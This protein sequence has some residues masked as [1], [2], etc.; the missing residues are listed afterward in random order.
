MR[1]RFRQLL[2]LILLGLFAATLLG[3]GL[4]SWWVHRPH[5]IY[6]G[7]LVLSALEKPVTV[8]YG[9]HAVPSIQ[10]ETL[11]DMLFA[12]GFVVAAERFWQMD[13]LRR[14]AGGRLAELFGEGALVADRFYRTIGLPLAAQRS[15]DALE[16]RWQR[17]LQA[18]ADGVNAYLS[19]ARAG[20]R[21]PLEYQLLGLQ[22]SPW[23]PQDSLLI[24]GYMAWLNSMNLREELVFLRLAQR[25]GTE[26]ALELFPTDQGQPAPADAHELPDYRSL[27]DI[28]PGSP[29]GAE[30]EMGPRALLVPP[31]SAQ[32]LSNAW[33]VTGSRTHDGAALLA[34]DP[35]LP[36]VMPGTWYELEMQ[37]P[38]Y[39]VAGVAL[40]GVPWILIGHNADLA[41]GITAAAADTQDLFLERVSEDGTRV[42]RPDGSWEPIAVRVERIAVAGQ[43]EPAEADVESGAAVTT[44]AKA[45]TRADARASQA[46]GPSAEPSVEGQ[47]QIE[48]PIRSTRHGV[49]IDELVASAGSNPAGLA[50]VRGSQRSGFR[51]A[52]RLAFDR[53]DRAFVGFYRLNTATTIAEARAAV[54]DLHQVSLSLLFAHRDGEIASQVSG[55]LP[56]RGR[57]SGTF[58]V[59]GWEP[60]YGWIGYRPFAQN[61]GITAPSDE[62]LVSANNAIRS[63]DEDALAISHS[64]LAPFRAQRIEALLDDAQEKLDLDAMQQMQSDRVSLEAAVYLS[65]LRRHLPAI[66]RADPEA[67]A[68][69]EANL[70][71]WSGGFEDESQP[72]AFFVLLRSELYRALYADELGSDLELLMG[73]DTNTYGPLAEAMYSDQSSFWDDIET[74]GAVEGPAAIWASALRATARAMRDVMPGEQ[75]PTLAQL[76]QLTFAH[77]FDGQP[78]LGSLFNLGPIGRG[79]DSGTIDVAIAPPTSPRAIGNVASVR[80]IFAPAVWSQ[81]RGTL[82]L[83]QSGH[84]FSRYRADQLDDW[85]NGRSHAWPWADSEA[86]PSVGTLVLQPGPD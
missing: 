66:R 68:L 36:A 69:A 46:L 64:W 25:L 26:R 77:A 41:W 63:D 21:L 50:A 18:Y 75:E 33:A 59:P 58:P 60:G 65:S 47:R 38:G 62:R 37:A 57:G 43:F 24:G 5:P 30:L 73:L 35:H 84:R 48:L 44:D 54:E 7:T 13:L 2:R 76:R 11:D 39:H 12:Q 72:A 74:P 40:P 61:P 15:F 3:V 14:L 9:P 42:L 79:G 29:S 31:A 10:A 22:P 83:G 52:L 27:L 67:A 23:Q 17:L 53:P 1:P 82:P 51:L 4:V 55:L 28:G 34:N 32:A 78:L 56:D 70:L 20:Y 71:D 8:R 80:V 16:P 6:N 19:R 81:T 85:L 49:L 86:R 45:D